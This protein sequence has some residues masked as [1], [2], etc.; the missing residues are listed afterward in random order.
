MSIKD[1]L[2]KRPKL[3]AFV[4]DDGIAIGFEKFGNPLAFLNGDSEGIDVANTLVHLWNRE[5]GHV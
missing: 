4:Q 5:Y 1:P 3:W 2:L